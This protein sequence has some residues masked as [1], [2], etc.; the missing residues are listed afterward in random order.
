MELRRLHDDVGRDADR[1]L[2]SRRGRR[3]NRQLAELLRSEP[4]RPMVSAVLRKT[5]LRGSRS[6]CPIVSDHVHQERQDAQLVLH[7]DRDSE[8]PTPQGYEFW[9]ALKTLGVP[10]QLVIYENEG[11]RITDPK[12]QLDR[13][14]RLVEW[15]D[16]YL[17]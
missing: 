3:G 12:H 11:H 10:T 7:G 4:H 15:F 13:D 6:L 14:R 16:R 5:R 1:A 8:V 2:P 9:H 17:R